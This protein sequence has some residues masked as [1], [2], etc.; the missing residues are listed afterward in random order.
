MAISHA[1]HDHPNTTAART[2]CRKAMAVQPHD[3]STGTTPVPKPAKVKSITTI[4]GKRRTPVAA[5]GNIKKPRTQLRTIGDL[6][7]VP[8]MLAYGARLAWANDWPV[9]VGTPFNDT[10]ARIEIH[11]PAGEISLVWR[12]SLPNGVWGVFWRPGYN[13]ITHRVDSIQGAFA[14]AADDTNGE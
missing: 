8:R 7:D 12:P 10:E 13:S 3:A 4:G 1:G 2:A 9:Y 14:M 5:T 6:P 11:A